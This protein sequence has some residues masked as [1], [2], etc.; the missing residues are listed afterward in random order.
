MPSEKKD[1][2]YWKKQID[3]TQDKIAELISSDTFDLQS[4][5]SDTDTLVYQDLKTRLSSLNSY[6]SYCERKYEEAL[7][8]ENPLSHKKT[9][10]LYFER[11]NG[12]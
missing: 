11:E 2:V 4:A 12:Y 6:L 5:K 9:S 1:S 8:L 3:L 7:E 10:I